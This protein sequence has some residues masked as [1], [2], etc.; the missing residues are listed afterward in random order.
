MSPDGS[1]S[2]F[3]T[4]FASILASSMAFIDGTALNVAMPALQAD[5]SASGEAILWILNSYLLMLAAFILVGGSAGDRLSRKKVFVT[6]IWIFISASMLCGIAPSVEFLILARVIQGFGGALM[7]PGSLAIITAVFAAEQRGKAI[8]T[9][10]MFATMVT[11]TG[12]LVGGLLA[13][14]GL[15]RGVFLIN[16]PLG[17]VGLSVLS[18]VPESRGDSKSSRLDY[19]GALMAA[20]SLAAITYGFLSMPGLGPSNPEVYGS[21]ISG[22][23]MLFLFVAWGIQNA[24]C[25]VAPSFV[26]IEDVQRHQSFDFVPIWRSWGWHVL[27]I[28]QHGSTPGVSAIDGRHRTTSVCGVSCFACP[29]V[30]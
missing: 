10:S 18:R 24:S 12:P 8:G 9:W 16:V 20:G 6:G 21:L 11:M 7:I 22:T 1:T 27:F 28:A 3:W 15:W 5:F 14:V 23:I 29:Y 25:D 17:I 2:K 26:S 30:G 19:V 4:L 13:D